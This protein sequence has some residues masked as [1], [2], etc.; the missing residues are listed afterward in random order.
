[1]SEALGAASGV[2]EAHRAGVAGQGAAGGGGRP[3]VGAGWGRCRARRAGLTGLGW[4]RTRRGS[5]RR[6]WLG[7]VRGAPGGG[8]QSELTGRQGRGGRRGRAP[9]AVRATRGRP[10]VGP[11]AGT[12]SGLGEAAGAVG[13]AEGPGAGVRGGPAGAE[14]RPPDGRD[15]AVTRRRG[16][17]QARATS[18]PPHLQ[19]LSPGFRAAVLHLLWV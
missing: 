5:G 15:Q 2:R 10:K 11:S 9:A 6:S 12:W 18:D 13:T 16:T 4:G 19:G 3:D 1:M 14:P 8:R 7:N 17:P